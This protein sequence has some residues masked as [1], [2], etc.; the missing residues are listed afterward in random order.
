M[1]ILVAAMVI[2]GVTNNWAA[3]ATQ[4]DL[5][6]PIV[7]SIGGLNGSFFTS[8][9]SLTNRSSSAVTADY[10]YTAAFGGGSGTASTLLDPGKQ[11]VVP[12]AISYL[13]S[14][15]IPIPE[16][17]GRGGTLRVNFSGITDT[18]D[19]AITVRTTTSVTAGRAGLAYVGIPLGE[20]LQGTAYLFGLRQTSADRTN[21]A[22]Q[23]MGVAADGD[24]T[25]RVTVISG[26]A[27]NATATALPDLVLPPGGFSQIN[28]VLQSNGLSLSNGYVKIERISGSAP[29][30]AYG[31]INDQVTSDGSFVPPVLESSLVGQTGLTVPVAVETGAFNSELVLTNWSSQQ[32]T[33]L[34]TFSA[35]SISNPEKRVT[36]TQTLLPGEQWIQPNFVQ[37]LRAHGFAGQLPAG[38]TYAGPLL[39]SVQGGDVSGLLAGVRTA[40]PGGGGS[41]RGFLPGS[42]RW[43]GDARQCLGLRFA[44]EH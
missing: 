24:V 33:V 12:D 23:N 41:I 13:K 31:V 6:V 25:L 9:L 27:G 19:V 18:N 14:L 34:V 3:P 40:S 10:T 35:D 11:L 29:Y 2:L 15:G 21:V 43:R 28:G 42:S 36:L 26:A 8:E 37:Y 30:Y 1:A 32:R 7:L 44:A 39:I 17:G 16:S 38:P 20:G 4:T 5:F 22:I